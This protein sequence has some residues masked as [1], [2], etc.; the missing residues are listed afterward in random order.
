MKNRVL[1]VF[2]TFFCFALF[3]TCTGEDNSS[4]VSGKTEPKKIDTIGFD[5]PEDLVSYV[6]GN[7]EVY[8]RSKTVGDVNYLCR[9]KP[10]E[11]ILAK[12]IKSKEGKKVT[13]EDIEDLQYFDLRIEIEEFGMEFLKYELESPEHYKQRV[14]YSA[15]EMQKD[16]YLVD[17][18]DTLPCVM[19]HFERSFDVTPF[20]HFSIAF[21]NSGNRRFTEKQIVFTDRLFNNGTIKFLFQSEDFTKAPVL[22]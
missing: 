1:I 19:F 17:G 15:F 13:K 9:L 6:E 10:I 14:A 8:I 11:Y 7:S 20:G 22:L 16:I 4:R 5:D 3:V 18:M 21:E 2:G 12:E